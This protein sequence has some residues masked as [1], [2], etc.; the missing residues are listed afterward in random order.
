MEENKPKED[1]KPKDVDIK[2]K[3]EEKSDLVKRSV[4]V[5]VGGFFVSSLDVIESCKDL[6]VTDVPELLQIN[7][8][9]ETEEG[10]FSNIAMQCLGKLVE[11]NKLKDIVIY[12]DTN[13]FNISKMENFILIGVPI[14]LMTDDETKSEF[15]DRCKELISKLNINFNEIVTMRLQNEE[16]SERMDVAIICDVYSY[17]DDRVDDNDLDDIDVGY[18]NGF[19]E[20]IDVLYER[21]QVVLFKMFSKKRLP[22]ENFYDFVDD[23]HNISSGF[24]NKDYEK[25]REKYGEFIEKGEKEEGDKENG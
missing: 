23:L 16:K 15:L 22:V 25:W 12:Y 11:K 6:L 7:T 18:D 3:E 5:C 24:S 14:Y 21:M 4:P 9:K 20:G 1:I 2:D 17:M 13:D 19:S 10:E 8:D